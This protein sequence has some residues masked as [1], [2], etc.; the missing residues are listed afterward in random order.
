MFIWTVQDIVNGIVLLLIIL[1]FALLG[2][3]MLGEKIQRKLKAW[4]TPR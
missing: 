4:R 1:F 2:L 3:V